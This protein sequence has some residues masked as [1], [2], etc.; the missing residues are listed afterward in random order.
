MACDAARY[1]AC[2]TVKWT[3]RL[4]DVKVGERRV[5]VAEGMGSRQRMVPV[6]ARFF[7]SRGDYL[8]QERR[9]ATSSGRVFVVLKL[10]HTCFTRLREGRGGTGG[11]PSPGRPRL[12]RLDPH[13]PARGK[14]LVGTGVPASHRSERPSESAAW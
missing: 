2:A 4:D 7:A 8:E 3:S 5:F 1:W 14:R 9:R 11:D 13:L 6:S 10:R 12:D